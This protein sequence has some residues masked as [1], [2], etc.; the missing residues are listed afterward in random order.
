MRVGMS[1]RAPPP[2]PAAE[3]LR[4]RRRQ[5]EWTEHYRPLLWSVLLFGGCMLIGWLWTSD[6]GSGVEAGR[7]YMD[8]LN[9]LRRLE[10]TR[11]AGLVKAEEGKLVHVRQVCVCVRVGAGGL[12][13]GGHTSPLWGVPR[14]RSE[15]PPSVTETLQRAF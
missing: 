4:E 1:M 14:R 11:A 6:G 13:V 2:P 9:S 7:A 5:R 3:S 8:H 10:T 15:G 12:L